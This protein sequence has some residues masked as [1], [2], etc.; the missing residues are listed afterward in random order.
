M[1]SLP[2]NFVQ[3][4]KNPEAKASPY[5]LKCTCFFKIPR[6]TQST[7]NQNRYNH[8]WSSTQI[9]MKPSIS[10]TICKVYFFELVLSL[11][12]PPVRPNSNWCAQFSTAYVAP[13]PAG[14][15]ACAQCS[16]CPNFHLSVSRFCW[17]VGV[18][19]ENVG[20]SWLANEN[21]LFLVPIKQKKGVVG[22]SNQGP[23][24]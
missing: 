15:G 16:Q 17:S 21:K 3:I 10:L 22:D 19:K 1:P 13:A 6:T 9:K 5:N 14:N 23:L 11:P 12:S 24:V 2:W 8:K 18:T 20:L 4:P 7:V